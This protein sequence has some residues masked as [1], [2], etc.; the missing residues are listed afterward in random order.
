MIF[1]AS[2]IQTAAAIGG[3]D[4]NIDRSVAAAAGECPCQRARLVEHTELVWRSPGPVE[5]MTLEHVQ[6]VSLRTF[7]RVGMVGH[8]T[9]H[10]R[11]GIVRLCAHRH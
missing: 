3:F 10:F 7:L 1:M 4:P 6:S 9:L 8:N 5:G 11:S 2:Q